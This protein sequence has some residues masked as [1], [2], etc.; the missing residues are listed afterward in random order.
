M[1]SK[2]ILFIIIGGSICL[3][4]LISAAPT[5]KQVGPSPTKHNDDE[6]PMGPASD[7][8]DADE[9]DNDN[10]NAS[11]ASESDPTK[12]EASNIAP[13]SEASMD[14]DD[15][16]FEPRGSD[17]N[18]ANAKIDMSRNDMATAAGHHHHHGHYAHGWL[19]MGAHTGH[20]GAFGWHDKHPVGKGRR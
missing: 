17:S 4:S 15:S 18:I 6:S 16:P 19:K 5:G 20:K 10:D 8:A 12:G 13:W 7:W 9:D 11:D 3:V 14:S 2:S 1:I